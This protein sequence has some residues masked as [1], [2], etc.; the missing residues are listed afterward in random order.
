MSAENIQKL[1]TYNYTTAAAAE[2][3]NNFLT[4]TAAAARNFSVLSGGG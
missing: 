1:S 4:V 3:S 2:I